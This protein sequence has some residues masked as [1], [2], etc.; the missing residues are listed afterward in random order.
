MDVL[1]IVVVVSII[2]VV[3]RI[4]IA[5]VTSITLIIVVT[6][7]SIVAETMAPVVA[8]ALVPVLIGPY[9]GGTGGWRVRGKGAN[10]LSSIKKK[11]LYY[12]LNN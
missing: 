12:L 11:K 6:V 4:I 9:E 2:I 1:T 5:T 7:I 10:S 8:V 3:T